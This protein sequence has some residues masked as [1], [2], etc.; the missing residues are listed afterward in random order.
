[1]PQHNRVPALS[2]PLN[3]HSRGHSVQCRHPSLPLADEESSALQVI[4]EEE[5]ETKSA[6]CGLGH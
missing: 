2:E 6:T 3:H 5:R 1:M 4:V